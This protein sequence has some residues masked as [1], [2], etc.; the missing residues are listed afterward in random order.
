MQFFVTKI[1][2]DSF[3]IFMPHAILSTRHNVCFVKIQLVSM[4]NHRGH[5]KHFISF[6]VGISEHIIQSSIGC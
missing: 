1:R 5:E 2:N 4:I 6:E 3:I